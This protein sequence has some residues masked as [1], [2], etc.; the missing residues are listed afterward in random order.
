MKAKV[1]NIQ[2][3]TIEDRNELNAE[4]QGILSFMKEE[5]GI[6]VLQLNGKTILFCSPDPASHGMLTSIVSQPEVEEHS[7]TIH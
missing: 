6:T 2:I 4:M 5:S 3:I 1:T 7:Q